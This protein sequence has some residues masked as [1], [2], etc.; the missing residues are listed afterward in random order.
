MEFRQL[1]R[2]GERISTIGMG[3]WKIGVYTSPAERAKQVQALRRGIE[4]G[5]NLIDTAETYADGKS[6]EIV[7]EAVRDVAK[8]SSSRP[9]FRRG[10]CAA[11]PSSKLA[12]EA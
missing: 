3:T 4:L 5:C 10:T 1:G 2:T 6:E 11:T 9:K 12:C 8:T 7:A